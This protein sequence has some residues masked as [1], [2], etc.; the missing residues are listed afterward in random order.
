MRD[1]VGVFAGEGKYLFIGPKQEK[2]EG[3]LSLEKYILT[4]QMIN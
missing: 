2:S 1:E 3:T 4:S